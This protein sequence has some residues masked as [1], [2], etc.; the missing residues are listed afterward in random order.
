M[1]IIERVKPVL[2][3]PH[4]IA[5]NALSLSPVLSL[6]VSL[7]TLL[8]VNK[9]FKLLHFRH[10]F[11]NKAILLLKDFKRLLIFLTNFAGKKTGYA[12]NQNTRSNRSLG[13]C[14]RYVC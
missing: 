5:L 9:F 12:I 6:F 2:A 14:V 11:L 13:E 7:Y 3:L 10:D 8:A 4:K 1:F